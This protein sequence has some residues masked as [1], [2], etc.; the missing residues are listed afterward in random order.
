MNALDCILTRASVRKYQDRTVE[1]ELIEKLLECGFH[2]PTAGNSRSWQF[3]VVQNKDT[4]AEMAKA[5]PGHACVAG[6]PLAIV[7]CVDWAKDARPVHDNSEHGVGAACENILLAAHALGLGG[8]WLASYPRKAIVD[9]LKATFNIPEGIDPYAVLSIG[10][11]DESPRVKG[12]YEDACVHYD[13][14]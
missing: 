8:V 12:F 10:Y 14:Y 11:P 7:C 9:H 2:A 4:L 13:S 6:A 1:K 3:I 5:A